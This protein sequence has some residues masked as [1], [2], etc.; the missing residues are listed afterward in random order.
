MSASSFPGGQVR[1]TARSC[2]RYESSAGVLAVALAA[3]PMKA[4]PAIMGMVIL[5]SQRGEG[6]CFPS[7]LVIRRDGPE[8]IAELRANNRG[9][10]SRGVRVVDVVLL[11]IGEVVVVGTV[12]MCNGN[13]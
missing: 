13:C 9:S 10:R 12:G 2:A 11:Q 8:R 3:Q 7:C 1:P 6:I 5:A 4:A